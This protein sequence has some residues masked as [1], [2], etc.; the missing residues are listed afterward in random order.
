MSAKIE[1]YIISPAYDLKLV[2]AYFIIQKFQNLFI[3]EKEH[4]LLKV[5]EDFHYL[6]MKKVRK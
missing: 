1:A 5:L 2:I 6:R 4:T 3:T